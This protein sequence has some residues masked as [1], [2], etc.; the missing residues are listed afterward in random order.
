MRYV[1]HNPERL[2]PRPA[3]IWA[4]HSCD[5]GTYLLETGQTET[6]QILPLYGMKWDPRV[7][8]WW[9]SRCS[10]AIPTTRHERAFSPSHHQPV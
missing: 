3:I 6:M 9:M 1:L 5:T 8:T 2:T 7:F 10:Y 4:I